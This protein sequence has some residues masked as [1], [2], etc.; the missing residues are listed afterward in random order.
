MFHSETTTVYK[1]T[2]QIPSKCKD[3]GDWQRPSVLQAINIVQLLIFHTKLTDSSQ[4]IGKQQQ[5]DQVYNLP[6]RIKCLLYFF[7]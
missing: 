7:P 3:T 5:A 2:Q 1:A 6:F 4:N